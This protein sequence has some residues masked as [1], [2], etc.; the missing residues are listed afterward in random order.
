MTNDRSLQLL[1]HDA[2]A[3]THPRRERPHNGRAASI[4]RVATPGHPSE[5]RFNE[6]PK[7]D[8]FLRAPCSKTLPEV[9]PAVVMSTGPAVMSSRV[10]VIITVGDPRAGARIACGFLIRILLGVGLIFA[11]ALRRSALRFWRARRH[12]NPFRRNLTRTRIASGRC[13]LSGENG[14]SNAV[15]A[16][17]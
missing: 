5:K 9:E 6:L 4:S 15:L 1:A 2:T 3:R 11:I 10:V 13:P 12:L 16:V 17:V 7:L 8:R 14:P